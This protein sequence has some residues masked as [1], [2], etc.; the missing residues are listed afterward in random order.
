LTVRT[1][2]DPC[3]LWASR[4]IDQPFLRDDWVRLHRA[5]HDVRDHRRRQARA[6]P[7]PFKRGFTDEGV[8]VTVD[9]EWRPHLGSKIIEDR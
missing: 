4:N 9:D 2:G 7:H 6:V 3:N 1:V 5:E 8:L